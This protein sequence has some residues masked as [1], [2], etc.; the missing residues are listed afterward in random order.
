LD[1]HPRTAE[2]DVLVLHPTFDPKRAN[3]M[4][5]SPIAASALALVNVTSDTTSYFFI[6]RTQDVISVE[7]N[8]VKLK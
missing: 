7:A 8:A 1:G 3:M 5:T 4:K 6:L 2:V